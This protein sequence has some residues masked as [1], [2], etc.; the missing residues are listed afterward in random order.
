[1]QGTRR[2]LPLLTGSEVRDDR[3][4]H[5]HINTNTSDMYPNGQ[6]GPTC[7]SRSSHTTA[8][9]CVIRR[10]HQENHNV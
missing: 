6:R 1:M 7:A 8:L 2:S 5:S 3:E 4:V 10:P 9:H